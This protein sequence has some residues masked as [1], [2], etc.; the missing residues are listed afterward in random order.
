M[1]VIKAAQVGPRTAAQSISVVQSTDDLLR[2]RKLA[3]RLPFSGLATTSG[4]QTTLATGAILAPPADQRLVIT[5]LIAQS[6]GTAVSLLFKNGAG[7]T[8]PLRVRCGEADGAGIAEVF[9]EGNE[10]RLSAGTAFIPNLSTAATVEISGKY[11]LENA[12]TGVPI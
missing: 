10:L 3:P 9:S 7:D 12:T 8:V 6:R 1:A 5:M 2:L 4:D 11:Y